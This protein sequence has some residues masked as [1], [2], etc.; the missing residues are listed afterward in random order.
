MTIELETF[1]SR[2]LGSFWWG[3]AG[4]REE[5]EVGGGDS[6]PLEYEIFPTASSPEISQ[7]PDLNVFLTVIL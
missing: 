5:G 7:V 4:K 2:R 6:F 1:Y 3:K